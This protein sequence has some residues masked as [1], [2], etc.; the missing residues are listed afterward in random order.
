MILPRPVRVILAAA[1]Y[2]ALPLVALAQFEPEWR[3]TPKKPDIEVA[4]TAPPAPLRPQRKARDVM[5][6]VSFTPPITQGTILVKDKDKPNAPAVTRFVEPAPGSVTLEGPFKAEVVLPG[7]CDW[8]RVRASVGAQIEFDTR[9]WVSPDN[10]PH[11]AVFMPTARQA[12][13][14][15]DGKPLP[16][17]TADEADPKKVKAPADDARDDA[18]ESQGNSS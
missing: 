18:Q 14:T 2:A 15:W 5:R 4:A 9:Y 6:V 8:K 10:E 3:H 17:K 16:Q 1:A 13:C 11:M 7:D 12:V